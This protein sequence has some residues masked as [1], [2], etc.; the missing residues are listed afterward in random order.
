MTTTT[1]IC[2][3]SIYFRGENQRDWLLLKDGLEQKYYSW[4]ATAMPDGA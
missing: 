1:T 2:A 3:Y 4:D